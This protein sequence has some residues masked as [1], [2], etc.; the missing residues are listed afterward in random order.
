MFSSKK[1]HLVKDRYIPGIIARQMGAYIVVS[2]EFGNTTTKS[3][4]TAT[5]LRTRKTY[6]VSK[7]VKRTVDVASSKQQDIFG[8]TV[9]GIPLRKDDVV[10]FVKGVL[11]ESFNDARLSPIKD[12]DF[13]VRSTGVVASLRLPEEVDIVIKALADGCLSAGIPPEKMI[14]VISKEQ[15]PKRLKELSFMDIFPFDGSV[16]GVKPLEK[17]VVA[18][19][20]EGELVTAGVK[21]A[22][23]WENID[24]RNPIVSL[25]FGTTLAGRVANDK[26]PVADVTATFAGYAGAIADFVTI[27]AGY[28]SALDITEIEEK[29]EKKLFKKILSE[30]EIGV[31]KNKESVGRV[32]IDPRGAEEKGII[33]VGVDADEERLM[34]I[35]RKIREK[36]MLPYL[37]ATFDKV[38]TEIFAEI[39]KLLLKLEL[40]DDRYS[41]GITGRAGITDRKPYMMVEAI[42]D[43]GIYKNTEEMMIFVE[44]A[45]AR[46]AAVMARCMHRLCYPKRPLCGV[47]GGKYP[48]KMVSR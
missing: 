35:G 45:L 11:A 41:I 25:D 48:Y 32:P 16:A 27:G 14:P 24:I 38:Y 2:V 22:A 28:T 19:E 10:R 37:R 1:V 34:E 29:E 30:V 23:I 4:I 9:T 44:D 42:K 26:V 17:S 21:D 18:N 36:D 7:I 5:D 33:I 8:M 6:M 20:M 39:I 43:M 40:V 15:L 47:R 3:L 31:I 13:V 46:G 12:I